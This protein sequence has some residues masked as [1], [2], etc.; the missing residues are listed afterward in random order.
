MQSKPCTALPEVAQ[1]QQMD[2]A[3]EVRIVMENSLQH[4]A[5]A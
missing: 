2:A 1:N 3:S 4:P 5:I